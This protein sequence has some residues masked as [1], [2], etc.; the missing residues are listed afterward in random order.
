MARATLKG[1]PELRRRLKAIRTV[2]KPVGLEW[3]ERTV[4]IAR[5][6][7]P[8]KTGRLRG[9][10]RRR[11][12]SQRKA[13]VVGHYSASFVD[14]GT[15]AHDVFAKKAETLSWSAGG[16]TFFRKRVHK[17]RTRARPFK[18]ESG[19]Q[20]LRETDILADLIKL[21]NEAA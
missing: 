16:T 5:G 18:R 11:N 14:K 12:A 17:E 7:V 13:S 3:T 2:F 21:W 10:I 4:R 15:Q 8:V 6:K 19:Q 9:S 1:A 20:A